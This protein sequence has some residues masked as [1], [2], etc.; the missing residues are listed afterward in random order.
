MIVPFLTEKQ[1]YYYKFTF[2]YYLSK[3]A[4]RWVLDAVIG[5]M[6][7]IES[8]GDRKDKCAQ[9]REASRSE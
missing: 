6:T 7:K 4:P 3:I 9:Y 1:L 8:S 5:M 2:A